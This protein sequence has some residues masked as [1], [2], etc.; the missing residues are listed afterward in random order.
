MNPSPVNTVLDVTSAA[1][2]TQHVP[3]PLKQRSLAY[4][5]V[6]VIGL[7]YV[8]LPTALLYAQRGFRVK[9]VDVSP[10]V[11]SL[12]AEGRVPEA[13]PELTPWW[14]EVSA[15]ETFEV[16]DTPTEADM[17]VITV[18][19]PWDKATHTCDLGAVNAAVDAIVPVL[20]KGNI[21]VLESTVPPGTT[22]NDIQPKIEAAGFVVGQD[23]HLCFSPERIL[24]GNTLHELIHNDRVLGGTTLES[25]LLTKSILSRAID[26]DIYIT[27]DITAE[28][29][30][31]AENTYR[32][33]NIALANELSRVADHLGVNIQEA[34]PIINHHPRVNLHRPGIGVGGHCI[35]VDPWFFVEAAPE[36]TPLIATARQVNDSMPAVSA[37][38]LLQQVSHLKNP[39]IAL[40]GLTYKPDVAD[41]RESPALEIVNILRQQ[42]VD[43]ITYD[44]LLPDYVGMTL[45]DAAQGADL[46]AV[47]VN[48]SVIQAE[49]SLNRHKLL[50][51]M[52]TPLIRVF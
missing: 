28:F 18:P 20:R 3:E 13:Y 16:S 51:M 38:K 8:G 44:P 17:F 33:V 12:I 4:Q 45:Y 52:R 23:I 49:I 27:N 41:V 35:A 42:G 40:V 11:L 43:V 22:R 19:T 50:G 36:L 39:R 30:K 6:A 46:L 5:T 29:C 7:G 25:A 24:P 2:S 48:H 31:L 47:L 10:R 37:R 9:G 14:R 32:D 15:L 1:L 34:L 26:G 21:V